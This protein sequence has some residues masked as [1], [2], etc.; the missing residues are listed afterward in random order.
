MGAL[1][2]VLRDGVAVPQ[3]SQAHWARWMEEN[4]K[5]HKFLLTAPFVKVKIG[6]KFEGVER[7]ITEEGLPLVWLGVV[8]AE[9]KVLTQK[10]Y[11]SKQAAVEGALKAAPLKGWRKRLMEWKAKR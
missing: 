11:P 1:T 5:H 3:P 8:F 7:G 4:A 9:G 10:L 6:V 2:Y